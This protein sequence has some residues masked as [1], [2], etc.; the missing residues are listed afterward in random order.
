MPIDFIPTAIVKAAARTF[1]AP[2]VS[3]ETFDGIITTLTGDTNPLGA[4]GYQTA[5]QTLPGA[6]VA[7]ETYK[8]TIEYIEETE[9]KTVG[10]IVITAPTRAI[11]TAAAAHLVADTTL[12][13]ATCFN[14]DAVQNTT[15][16]SWN[17][18][19]RIHDPT[20]EIYYL[21]LTRK[22]LKLSS[23]E[24]D[25]ILTKVDTWADTVAALN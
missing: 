14:G 17:V 9:G 4:S 15:K 6:A 2:I 8:A 20:G 10:S 23:Y 16:D 1:T 12:A 21:T 7:D 19:V 11:I 5:G 18:R 25:E 13:G 24:A 22:T 3:A